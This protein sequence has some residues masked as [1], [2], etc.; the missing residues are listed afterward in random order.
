MVLLGKKTMQGE[1]LPRDRHLRGAVGTIDGSGTVRRIHGSTWTGWHGKSSC[2][3]P[4][5]LAPF[6]IAWFTGGGGAGIHDEKARPVLPGRSFERAAG[7]GIFF[8][9]V[10]CVWHHGRAGNEGGEDH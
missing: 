5:Q 8:G 6:W 1:G 3:W 4:W 10:P 2:S 7:A 9:E